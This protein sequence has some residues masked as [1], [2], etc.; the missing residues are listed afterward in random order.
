MKMRKFF[1]KLLKCFL[2]V[3]FV[4]LLILTPN[5][6]FSLGI[7]RGQSSVIIGPSGLEFLWVMEPRGELPLSELKRPFAVL[8]AES[9][10]IKLHIIRSKL[11]FSPFQLGIWALNEDYI[12]API[13]GNGSYVVLSFTCLSNLVILG[14]VFYV[15]IFATYKRE[16][17]KDFNKLKSLFN[18]KKKQKQV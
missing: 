1:V 2:L 11:K 7:S 14:W 5:L 4:S 9:E 12:L 8:E 10:E 18:F 16:V 6:I 15:A 3:G 13:S 17:L